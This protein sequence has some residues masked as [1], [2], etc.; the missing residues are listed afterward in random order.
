[1]IVWI[2]EPATDLA[3]S[4][5]LQLLGSLTVRAFASVESLLTITRIENAAPPNAIL[6]NIAVAKPSLEKI[7]ATFTDTRIVVL[8]ACAIESPAFICLS[9]EV[10]ALDLLRRL[11]ESDPQREFADFEL[12]TERSRLTCISVGNSVELTHKERR[13]VQLLLSR[14]DQEIARDELLS[15]VWEGVKI[16]PRTL[17]SHISRLRTKLSELGMHVACSYRGGYRLSLTSATAQEA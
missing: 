15:I 6:I 17:D 14:A 8:G 1:M 12:D 13:L 4:R 9:K 11:R 3:N 5:A 16:A 7:A 10:S 2:L